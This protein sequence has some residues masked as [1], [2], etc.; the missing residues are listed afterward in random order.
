[1]TLMLSGRAPKIVWS[2]DRYD[3]RWSSAAVSE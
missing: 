3:P 1:L 2:G